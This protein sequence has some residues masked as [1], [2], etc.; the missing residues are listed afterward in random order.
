MAVVC[1]PPFNVL[2]LVLFIRPPS[3]NVCAAIISLQILL[4]TF[5]TSVQAQT[6]MTFLN[7]SDDFS[8]VAY[9]R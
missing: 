8:G 4:T 2:V 1:K 7:V 5:D 6:V 9:C 3:H